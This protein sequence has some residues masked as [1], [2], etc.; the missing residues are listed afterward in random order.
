[1]EAKVTA[2]CFVVDF[3]TKEMLLIYNKKAEKW[4]QPGGHLEGDESPQQT[5]IRQLKK[6]VKNFMPEREV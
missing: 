5:V 6:K 2:S 3:D 4:I 1:M